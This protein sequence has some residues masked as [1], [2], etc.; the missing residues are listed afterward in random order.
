MCLE[1]KPLFIV[2]S[3]LPFIFL[4]SRELFL[5]IDLICFVKYP[6]LFHQSMI[7]I[8]NIIILGNRIWS[9]TNNLASLNEN[10]FRIACVD[11]F[12]F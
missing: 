11:I 6:F 8:F 5:D 4:P 2:N 9:N 12:S 3:A 1:I 10:K 7:L